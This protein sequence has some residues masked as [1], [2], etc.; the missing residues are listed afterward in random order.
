MSELTLPKRT[1]SAKVRPHIVCKTLRNGPRYYVYAWRGGP[2]VLKRDELRPT[3]EEAIQASVDAHAR[4]VESF[5]RP[6]P[7]FIQ[8]LIE[9]ARSDR[10]T[11]F[12]GTPQTAIKIG[13]AQCVKARLRTLQASSPFQLEVLAKVRGGEAL[14]SAY[15]S[16]FA[17]WRKHGEWFRPHL[18]ILTEIDRL[19]SDET[20]RPATALIA[21][22]LTDGV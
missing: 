17:K 8:E 13:A 6:R 4:A 22:G 18:E 14:E 1:V 2:L 9:Q 21:Q 15:H 19:N 12:I 20:E 3:Q 10:W 7:I 5:V 11:Y 16:W